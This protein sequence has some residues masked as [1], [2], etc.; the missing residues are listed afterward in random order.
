MKNFKEFEIQF[1]GLKT[2]A[3]HF[4]YHIDR[5]FFELFEYDEFNTV[6]VQ[7][8]LLLEKKPNMLELQFTVHGVVNVN[9]DVS[10][11]AY[12]QPIEGELSLVVKFGDTY[13]DKNDD[14]LILPQ[15]EYQLEVQHYI[16][17]AIIL[18]VPY[19]KVHPKVV[20]GTMQSELLDKLEELSPE[21]S[22]NTKEETDPR[23]DKL[24]E[25]LNEK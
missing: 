5:A 16:Y 6:D 14:L 18:A 11:E 24:K 3:H 19:K 8:E 20:D 12:D 15:G 1:I 13:N 10:N 25:L 21:N 22:M 4:D 23:W 7:V 9:C 2:E 17:E